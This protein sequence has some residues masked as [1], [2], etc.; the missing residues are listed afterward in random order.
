MAKTERGGIRLVVEN[1]EQ[2]N[3]QLQAASKT[4]SGFGQSA[5]QTAQAVNASASEYRGSSVVIEQWSETVD[6]SA[7]RAAVAAQSMTTLGL[8]MA[9]AGTAAIALMTQTGLTASRIEELAALLGHAR[10]VI[11]GDTGPVHLAASFKTPTL[12]V[13]LASDWRRNG[14]LGDPTAVVSGASDT[15]SVLSWPDPR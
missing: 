13:F 8:A 3:R 2:F 1:Y 9:A 15:A 7:D 14:P 12:A 10:L 4:M 5:Q 11:G 6:D